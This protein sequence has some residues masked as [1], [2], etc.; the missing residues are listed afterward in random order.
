MPQASFRFYAELNDF[1]KPEHRG[2]T[3]VYQFEVA[4]SVKHVIEA[5]GV[6]HTEVDLLLINSEPADFSR[7]VADGDR[8]SVYPVFESIDITAATRVRP[9]P[10]RQL[11]FVLDCHLGRL[12]KYLRIL[13]FDTLYRNRCDDTELAEIAASQGRVLLT[14]DR[15]LL[16]R[17]KVER[18]YFVR[19]PLPRR[20]L[21]EVLRRFDLCGAIAPF[22]RC[23]RCNSELEPVD[24]QQVLDQIPPRTRAWC[25]EY[26]RCP[27]CRKIYWKGSHYERM[28]EFVDQFACSGGTS[29]PQ[30]A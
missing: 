17:A 30:P 24:K 1:L 7:L 11:R 14:M 3:L 5:Y 22:Q 27:D 13:G 15:G 26:Q 20:Q 4:P 18:G 29:F 25:D 19:E 2:E 10:L 21:I 9:Q 12:A 6:P 23:L 16:M 8:V 28:R